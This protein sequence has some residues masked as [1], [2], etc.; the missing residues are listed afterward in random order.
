MQG[1][2]M[3]KALQMKRGQG[4]QLTISLD[5]V[6]GE[7]A[8]VL[9]EAPETP[10]AMLEGQPS[11]QDEYAK[12]TTEAAPEAEAEMSQDDMDRSLIADMSDYDKEMLQTSK[13]KS[14]GGKVRLSAMDRLKGKQA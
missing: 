1:D 11:E 8:G 7:E 13:P 4:F 9:G 5:P 12:K 6:E 3:K 2:S 10:E 14:F